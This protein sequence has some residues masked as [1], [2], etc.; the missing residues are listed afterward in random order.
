MILSLLIWAN[1]PYFGAIIG[2][3]E[4]ESRKVKFSLG[5]YF[6]TVSGPMMAKII[7]HEVGKGF[8]KVVWD[9]LLSNQN[10]S[11]AALKLNYFE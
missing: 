3:M 11:T 9:C 1:S 8:D 10:D 4:I 6:L 2:D 5:V 7:L